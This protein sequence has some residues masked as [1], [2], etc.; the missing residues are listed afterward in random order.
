MRPFVWSHRAVAVK[1]SH[2]IHLPCAFE[3]MAHS[4]PVC[5][6]LFLTVLNKTALHAGKK[7]IAAWLTGRSRVQLVP[8]SRK[9]YENLSV[10]PPLCS[11]DATSRKVAGSSPYELID[12]FKFTWSFHPH[13]GPGVYSAWNRLPGVFFLGGGGGAQKSG[14]RVRLTT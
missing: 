5:P 14:R 10:S 9:A 11:V 12:F 6:L 4:P 1:G 8:L 13:Y 2:G 3:D 7:H